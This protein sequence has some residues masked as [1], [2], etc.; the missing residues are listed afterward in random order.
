MEPADTDLQRVSKRGVAHDLNCLACCKTELSQA[1]SK[2]VGTCYGM[3]AALFVWCEISER[4]HSCTRLY[5][6]CFYRSFHFDLNEI[7]NQFQFD[8]QALPAVL[9]SA[10]YMILGDLRNPVMKTLLHRVT[11]TAA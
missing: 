7:D 4:L 10:G 1:L 3:D 11:Q 2:P 6:V 5:V 9:T 8:M